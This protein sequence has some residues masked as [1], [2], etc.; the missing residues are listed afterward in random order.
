[1]EIRFCANDRDVDD[2][3]DEADDHRD[4]IQLFEELTRAV[5]MPSI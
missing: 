1:M 3:V 2:L 5:P 4:V